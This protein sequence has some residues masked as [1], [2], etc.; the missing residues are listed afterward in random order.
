MSIDLKNTEQ[1]EGYCHYCD[2]RHCCSV[3]EPHWD[4]KEDEPCKE[5]VLGR[6]FHCA[7]RYA[8]NGEWVN[9]VCDDVNDYGGCH[10][11]KPGDEAGYKY[12]E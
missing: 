2:Y 9:G 5:F 7:I 4:P 11:F 12:L 3:E 8:S 6:C 10:N 1:Y